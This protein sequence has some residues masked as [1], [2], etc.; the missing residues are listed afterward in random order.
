M[1]R[2]T[3]A[4]SGAGYAA[5]VP[6]SQRRAAYKEVGMPESTTIIAFDQHADSLMAAVLPPRADKP[7]YLTQVF[8]YHF[9][10]TRRFSSSSKCCTTTICRS[11]P[12]T[13]SPPRF[14]IMRNRWPSRDTS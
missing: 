7:A 13:S 12:P 3:M 11:A 2:P 10:G 14:L 4:C 1:E 5:R 9:V 6:G 8:P